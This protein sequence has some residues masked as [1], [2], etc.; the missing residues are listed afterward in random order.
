MNYGQKKPEQAHRR[1]PFLFQPVNDT[2]D[3]AVASVV[4]DASRKKA[5]KKRN[6][7][8]RTAEDI[9]QTMAEHDRLL[10]ISYIL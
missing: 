9:I 1:E 4:K 5:Q 7:N 2:P 3:V 8:C 6:N 10:S